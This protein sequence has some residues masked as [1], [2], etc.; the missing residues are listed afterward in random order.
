MKSARWATTETPAPWVSV[1][2]VPAMIESRPVASVSQAGS[3]VAART[4]GEVPTATPGVST[5]LQLG[6]GRY[7]GTF[8]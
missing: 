2:S 7:L 1:S 3:S 6:L 8:Y 4:A 5:I